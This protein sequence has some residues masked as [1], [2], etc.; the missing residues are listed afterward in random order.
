MNEY[1]NHIIENQSVNV[2]MVTGATITS[3]AVKRAV[4]DAIT[5][6]G[7]KVEDF[8]KEIEKATPLE[9]KAA[10]VIV[11]GGGGAGLAAAVA[12]SENGASVIIVEKAGYVGGNTMVSGGI[13]NAPDEKLQESIEMTKGS[14]HMIEEAVAEEPVNDEHKALMKTVKKQLDEYKESGKTGLFDTKEWFALQTWNGGDKVAN[15]D[16]VKILTYQAYDAMEWVHSLGWVYTDKVN[17]GP[18]ALYP[19]T[20]NSID[21]LG[22]GIIKAY[23]DTL[24]KMDNVEIIFDTEVTEL[25]MDGE[26]VV[27]AKGKDKEGNV[28]TF[29]A[30]KGVILSTGGFAGNLKMIQEYNTS[31]KWPDLSKTKSTNLPAI[32][33]DGIKMAKEA[34]AALIDMD[35]IQLLYACDPKT[36]LATHGLLD[37]NGMGSVIY[38]NKE[39][40]R[41]VR[42]DGRRDEISLGIIAQTDG[43]AYEIASAES[44]A[45]LETTIDLGGTAVKDLIA[46]NTVFYGETLEEACEKAGLPVDAVKATVE[47]YNKLVEAQVDNDEFGKA[48]FANKLENGPWFVTPR[49]PSVH[50][51]M[52]GVV[53][54][55]HCQVLNEKGETIEGLL[56]AGEITG[57]IHGANRLGGNAIVDTIVFGK[58]A[59]EQATK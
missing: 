1:P 18:G 22:T 32:K 44:G 7:G 52:G 10:D 29:K 19:R 38:V 17:A 25:L 13:Y 11:V 35:Q 8:Q 41:F 37:L 48:I 14:I 34:G 53:I 58:I 15:L 2:D 57:G 39:G 50:H 4:E 6:A 24:G 3:M 46:G 59:G 20:H 5:Q 12:A 54:N 42:E 9:E 33:G 43:V 45:D 21:P 26:K 40:K 31:G 23:T 55:E 51:T 28:S 27:G 56:A 16:L 47:E 36:G 30:N 49:A